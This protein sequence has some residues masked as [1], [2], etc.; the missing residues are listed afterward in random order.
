MTQ[1]ATARAKTAIRTVGV[2]GVAAAIFAGSTGVAHATV[3]LNEGADWAQA[4][5]TAIR[6]YDGERDGNGVYADAY[7]V[8]GEHVSAWDGNGADGNPGPWIG[9]GGLIDRFRVCEDHGKCSDWR[10]QPS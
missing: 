9:A 6:A 10:Y 2:L 3:Q 7:L 4:T 8:T 1:L 5:A